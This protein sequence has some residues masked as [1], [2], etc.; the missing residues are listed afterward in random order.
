MSQRPDQCSECGEGVVVPLTG[1]CRDLWDLVLRDRTPVMH[2]WPS[3]RWQRRN[4]GVVSRGPDRMSQ[5]D[6]C[7]WGCSEPGDQWGG[8]RFDEVDNECTMVPPDS[9]AMALALGWERRPKAWHVPCRDGNAHVHVWLGYY[10]QESRWYVSSTKGEQCYLDAGPNE[11]DAVALAL[12][13]WH[14]VLM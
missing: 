11:A 10:H 12:L 3:W 5:L 2:Q 9:I 8:L 14:T 6:G 7:L 4:V 1:L 13:L